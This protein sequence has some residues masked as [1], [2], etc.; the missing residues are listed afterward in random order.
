MNHRTGAVVLLGCAW[1][2]WSEISE[3]RPGKPFDHTWQTGWHAL[4]SMSECEQRARELVAGWVK[5]GWKGKG[6]MVT[7]QNPTK[8][9]Y[10]L[11]QYH[12]LPSTVDPRRP[13]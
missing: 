8:N 7:R 11:I 13:K 3:K 6:D 5:A 10:S 4:D 2:H 9:D 1:F 12:C